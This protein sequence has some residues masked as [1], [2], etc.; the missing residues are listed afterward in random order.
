[1]DFRQMSAISPFHRNNSADN[2][3]SEHNEPSVIHHSPEHPIAAHDYRSQQA[4]SK[5]SSSSWLLGPAW[6]VFGTSD[7]S[8]EVQS[9]HD[10]ESVQRKISSTEDSSSSSQTDADHAISQKQTSKQSMPSSKLS[11]LFRTTPQSQPVYQTAAPSSQSR[12]NEHLSAHPNT[13]DSSP[14]IDALKRAH[15]EGHEPIIVTTPAALR[16]Q[17]QN[18]HRNT[19]PVEEHP[20]QQLSGTISTDMSMASSVQSALK[21]SSSLSP[22]SNHS[23]VKSPEIECADICQSEHDAVGGMVSA[24]SDSF[25]DALE[26]GPVFEDDDLLFSEQAPLDL[27]EASFAEDLATVVRP[28]LMSLS[29]SSLSSMDGAALVHPSGVSSP[30]QRQHVS[31]KMPTPLKQVLSLSDELASPTKTESHHLNNHIGALYERSRS[32][33]LS[34]PSKSSSPMNA[35]IPPSF[36]SKQT[37]A[38]SQHAIE[39]EHKHHRTPITSRTSQISEFDPI[40]TIPQDWMMRFESP[41]AASASV[42][43]GTHVSSTPIQSLLDVVVPISTPNSILKF[44]QRDLDEQRQR[45]QKNF[46]NEFEVAQLE[47]QDLTLSSQNLE[48]ENQKMKDTLKQ[49]EQ[50]VKLMITEKDKDKQQ[51]QAEIDRLKEQLDLAYAER[52]ESKKE[53]DQMSL[54]YKQLRV[55]ISDLKELDERQ[56]EQISELEQTVATGNQRFDSLRAH[57]ETKLDEA[58]VEIARVRASYEKEAAAMRAKLSRVEIQMQTLDC[59]LKT[60]VQENQELTKICD[61]LV[62][63]MESIGG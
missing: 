40:G 25:V 53:L 30:Q 15:H 49:W 10:I 3:Q 61:D 21:S 20:L 27:L 44:S 63:Q 34:T 39:S 31:T 8:Q 45:L 52:N 26:R 37:E 1:M 4:A 57:A 16:K 11:A 14:F 5:P 62:S 36:N 29:L 18:L 22:L 28:S 56:R 51:K 7:P 9:T 50:A 33:S 46:E 42:K 6:S 55:D 41:A 17:T 35:D 58:N 47:I 32:L 54:K 60:K 2:Q 38:S 59:N 24:V 43:Y 19:I 13:D 23:V 48:R 12:Q